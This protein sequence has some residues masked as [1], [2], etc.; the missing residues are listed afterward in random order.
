MQLFCVKSAQIMR[1]KERTATF[2]PWFFGSGRRIRTFTKIDI[3]TGISASILSVQI[4]VQI[5]GLY[6]SA[7][8]AS[9]PSSKF[10]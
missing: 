10:L 6:A 2:R 7:G 4:F 1:Q 3:T 9:S 5:F 8:A